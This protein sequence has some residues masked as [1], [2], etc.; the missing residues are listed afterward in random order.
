MVRIRVKIR[1]RI[2]V[3]IR[4]NVRVRFRIWNNE[5]YALFG[6]TN[7]LNNEPSE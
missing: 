5:P 4:V 3:R 6:I 2:R 1:V 7:F